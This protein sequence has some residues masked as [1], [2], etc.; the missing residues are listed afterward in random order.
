MGLF[1]ELFLPSFFKNEKIFFNR[2]YT[3]FSEKLVSQTLL[4]KE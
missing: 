4:K 3:Y 2:A 1:L